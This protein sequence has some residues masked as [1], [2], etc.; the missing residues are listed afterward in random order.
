MCAR[1]CVWSVRLSPPSVCVDSQ[2]HA[3]TSGSQRT[4]LVVACTVKRG[5]ALTWAAVA[6]KGGR[7]RAPKPTLAQPLQFAVRHKQAPYAGYWWKIALWGQACS[8][9]GDQ[10][11]VRVLA[12]A[13]ANSTQFKRSWYKTTQI[14]LWHERRRRHKRCFWVKRQMASRRHTG[15]G[16]LGLPANDE[17]SSALTWLTVPRRSCAGGCHHSRHSVAFGKCDFSFGTSASTTVPV[18]AHCKPPLRETKGSLPFK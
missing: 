7:A 17:L 12:G 18:P 2:G 14:R 1:V 6:S 8:G 11:F 4:K 9:S 13:V 15:R 10:Q 16:G 3:I 5:T